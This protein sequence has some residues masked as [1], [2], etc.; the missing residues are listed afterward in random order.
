MT[1]SETTQLR[2]LLLPEL[3]AE[4]AKTRLM[5][6]NLPE[7]Q[8]SF[9]PAEKSMTL[10]RLAGHI[11]EMPDY[12]ALILTSPDIEVT[13]LG[14]K[15]SLFETVPQVLADFNHKA[16]QVLTTFKATSDQT[17]Q[18]HW[19]LTFKGHNL[20][21]G[22]RY[23]A[24]REMGLDQMIH[25]RGQLTVYLRLLGAKVP[26]TYGPSADDTF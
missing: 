22:T 14:L 8:T 16:D 17:F 25:H 6:G 9:K 1:V 18:Q 23:A 15:P 24:Y 7:G 21:S 12:I 19:N 4:F 5:L 3:E 20:F 13:A 11:A 26:G 10:G 2:Q